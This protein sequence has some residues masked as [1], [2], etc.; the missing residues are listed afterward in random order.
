MKL[1]LVTALLVLGHVSA[2]GQDIQGTLTVNGKM[3]PIRHVYALIHDD[4]EGLLLYPKQLRILLT[5]REVPPASLFGI[6]FLPIVD[7]ANQGGAQGVLLQFNPDDRA[8]V[9]FNLFVKGG[10]FQTVLDRINTKQLE[11]TAEQVTGS[12]QYRDAETSLYSD[13]RP[14]VRFEFK[15]STP[16][17]YEPPVT[18]ELKGKAALNSPQMRALSAIIDAMIEGDMAKLLSHSSEKAKI[19]INT[20]Y[21]GRG[22]APARAQIRKFA[23]ETKRLFAK[24]LRIVVRGNRATVI[25]P[26]RLAFNLIFEGGQWKSDG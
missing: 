15:F 26:D 18:S 16:L 19:T 1:F 7:L 23:A 22:G 6:S 11:M 3:I 25:F 9:E 13:I 8:D 12:V 10:G 4:A 20:K 2:V 21:V 5:D 14:N 17:L 24:V